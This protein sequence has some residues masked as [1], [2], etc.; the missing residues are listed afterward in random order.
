[1]PGAG[2]GS[3]GAHDDAHSVGHAEPLHD[4]AKALALLGVVNSA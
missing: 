4:F 2:A 1:M 3:H